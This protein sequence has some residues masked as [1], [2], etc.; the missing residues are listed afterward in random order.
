MVS[1]IIPTYNRAALVERAAKSVLSQSYSDLELIIVDDG[2]TDNTKML[3]ESLNDSRVRYIYQQNSGACAARN[4]GIDHANGEYIAFHDSDD[5]WHV[6]KLEKQL[7]ILKSTD[8]DLVFCCMNNH[9][10]GR[11]IGNNFPEGICAAS[12]LPYG[13]G[14]QTLCANSI[15]FKSERFDENMPRLQD[16]ELLLRI[17]KKYKIYYLNEP[18]V[19]YYIQDDSISSNPEKLLRAWEL[20]LKKNPDLKSDYSGELCKAALGLLSITSRVN[21]QD[22]NQ[23]IKTA[24]KLN[25]SA[26]V[27]IKSI[28]V[29]F[30]FLYKKI[31]A[32]HK[33]LLKLK[34]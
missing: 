7:A 32:V 3:L 26:R 18:L 24:L 30:P 2:S 19:D 27:I 34:I 9:K 22:K 16:F 20:I 8:A 23:V 10:T 17:A 29:R 25:T 1:V 31:V 13:V 21:A 33:F 15:V 5:V 14:T 4:N 6:D 28:L 11:L 12:I